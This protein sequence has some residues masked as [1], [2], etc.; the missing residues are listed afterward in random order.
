MTVPAAISAKKPDGRT[1]DIE[2]NSTPKSYRG[3]NDASNSIWD[4]KPTNDSILHDQNAM[5]ILL[6]LPIGS[7]RESARVACV[8]SERHVE[9][10][11]LYDKFC[12]LDVKVLGDL[13]CV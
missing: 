13:G 1:R 5:H 9:T 7:N 4:R 11:K 2:I 3:D 8:G 6:T 12:D 10:W